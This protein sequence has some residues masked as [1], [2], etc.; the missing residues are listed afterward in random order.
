MGMLRRADILS[1]IGNFGIL[2]MGV[3]DN[4]PLSEP[5]EIGENIKHKLQYVRPFPQAQ[6]EIAASEMDK[7]NPRYGHPTMYR[8][9]F[10]PWD[11][12]L[13][14]GFTD[15]SMQEVHWTRVVHIADNREISE[16]YGIPRLQLVYNACL[17]LEK[18]FGSSGEM[19]YKGAYPGFMVQATDNLL[20]TVQL[21]SES[22]RSEVE[23]YENNLQR[24]MAIKNATIQSLSSSYAD[25]A[26]HVEVC[27]NQIAIGIG[28][29]VRI[30]LGS[31]RGELASNQDAV[32]WKKRPR[33]GGIALSSD[34]N[35]KCGQIGRLGSMA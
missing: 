13:D 15:M 10:Q 22:I 33:Q 31:E 34:F 8:I 6:I 9:Q 21:D 7:R 3:G 29:P 19:F 35:R 32:I 24:W 17:D 20:N 18:I 5:V 11:I 16:I 2:L 27:I 25:P 26:G 30:L 12:E 23:K 4:K 1:G 28:C 14:G